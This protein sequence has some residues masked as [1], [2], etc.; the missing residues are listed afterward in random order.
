MKKKDKLDILYEDK[1]LI[2]VNK[3]S[4]ILTISTDKEYE[5]TLYSEVSNYEK[6]K[7]KKNKIFIV[8]RL[9]KDTSGIVIFAKNIHTKNILQNSW[10]NVVRK[11]IAV[12]HGQAKEKEELK[13]YL[14]ETK[15]F[16][17]FSTK[18]PKKGKL[19]IT[20]YEKITEN[21][22]YS[23]LSINIKT[24][25]KNQIRV[26]LSDINQPIVGDKKYGNKKENQKRLFLHANFIE[27]KH[28]ITSKIITIETGIPKEFNTLITIPKTDKKLPSLLIK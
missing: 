12:V 24:G 17:V 5:N 27:F 15:T 8:H 1:N 11:Y 9:D 14:F 23:L 28:P 19:A 18:N 26:Q 4:G 2:V 13:S 20:E 16:Q 10:E 22:K 3:K 6:K 7:D 21:S 25:R